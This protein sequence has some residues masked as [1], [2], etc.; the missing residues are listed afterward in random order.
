MSVGCVRLGIVS[1]SQ[2]ILAERRPE[3]RVAFLVLQV[4]VVG[5]L[6]YAYVVDSRVILD[7]PPA[8]AFGGLAAAA[9]HL[10][11]GAGT[12][13]FR[14]GNSQ[15]FGFVA[16]VVEFGSADTDGQHFGAPLWRN[17]GGLLFHFTAPFGAGS[18]RFHNRFDITL[19]AC[20]YF[21]KSITWEVKRMTERNLVLS[22]PGCATLAEHG[23]GTAIYVDDGGGSG[24]WHQLTCQRCGTART[25]RRP[26][27]I[28]HPKAEPAA[29][30]ISV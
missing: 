28:L 17:G 21:V 4:V 16:E 12:H 5:C 13:Q 1:T 15:P 14:L 19:P 24:W 29:E 2:L 25:A 7:Q 22:C 30:L 9:S 23:H 10:I 20:L 8:C 6:G 27:R 26:A 11:Q 3:T 18:F